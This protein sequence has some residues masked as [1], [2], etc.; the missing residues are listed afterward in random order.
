MLSFKHLFAAAF[1]VGSL[2]S[3]QV[4]Q[5]NLSDYVDVNNLPR[6]GVAATAAAA[7]YYLV[8]VHKADDKNDSAVNKALTIASNVVKAPITFYAA[9]KDGLHAAA[10]AFALA[11]HGKAALNNLNHAAHYFGLKAP[12]LFAFYCSPKA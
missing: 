6:A 7:V 9:K 5:A 12:A 1:V 2:L 4:A 8:S 10:A 11:Y 3:T